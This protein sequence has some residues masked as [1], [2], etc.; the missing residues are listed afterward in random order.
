ML[1]ELEKAL[2]KRLQPFMLNLLNKL[3]L[4]VYI[5][6][7]IKRIHKK[8]SQNIIPCNEM[9]KASP[10]RT[11]TRQGLII[12]LSDIILTILIRVIR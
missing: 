12:T 9:L 4:E 7:Q 5:F 8:N 2:E 11:G 3:G 10:L 6:N 1:M